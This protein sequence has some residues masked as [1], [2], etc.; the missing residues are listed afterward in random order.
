MESSGWIGIRENLAMLRFF[1]KLRRDASG[2]TAVEYGLI[3]GLISVVTI[4]GLHIAG[5]QLDAT[6]DYIGDRLHVVVE[7]AP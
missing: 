6:F 2:A 3:A 5:G 4:A 1:H 7:N